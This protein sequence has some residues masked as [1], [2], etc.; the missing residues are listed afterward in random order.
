MFRVVTSRFAPVAMRRF[1]STAT[2]STSN[3]TTKTVAT[4]VA[5]AVGVTGFVAANTSSC[6]WL[7]PWTWFGGSTNM[8]ALRAD[9]EDIIDDEMAGPVFVRLA[10]HC[11]GTYDK[12]SGTGGSDGATMRFTPESTDGANAGL[13]KARDML[14]PLKAKY[15]TI[16]YA[17]LYTFAGVV[18]VEYMG[19]PTVS[20][21]AG[22][23]DA[24]DGS[25]CPPNGRLPDAA[26]GAAHLRDVFYRMGFN[27][28]EIVC[29]TGAHTLGHCHIENSGFDG[30][31][32]RD[33]YGLD[34]DFFRLL[35]EET[36]SIRPNFS[37]SQY[38]NSGKDLMMLPADMS[39]VFDPIFKQ[40]VELYAKDG[41]LW[42]KDFAAAFGKLLEL[43]VN[44]N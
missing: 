44:R 2:G 41:D 39:L 25:T 19:C 13:G 37:P 1:A 14:E 34:N 11:S 28:R 9:I 31:W 17:D 16:S 7:K 3:T 35:L 30:P 22:R 10:W 33:P 32:T 18:A 43:G 20:W 27:D 12:N 40:Y 42:A 15:P 8:S 29:L 26:Q 4:V 38:E 23:T 24:A 6:D 21:K 36:W 5:A